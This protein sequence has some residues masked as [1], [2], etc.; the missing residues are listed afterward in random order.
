[1]VINDFM[2]GKTI[3][4]FVKEDLFK[5]DFRLSNIGYEHAL[6]CYASFENGIV[7]TPYSILIDE[8]TKKV[9]IVIRGTR[10][11]EG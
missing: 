3:T 5:M 2:A 11:V 4:S 9:V 8:E 6:L 7:A 1:M 10:S